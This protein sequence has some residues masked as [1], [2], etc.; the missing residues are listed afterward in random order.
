MSFINKLCRS[1]GFGAG[2]DYETDTNELSDDAPEAEAET[3]V[4][5]TV[6]ET[7]VQG[8]AED[9]REAIFAQVLS[10][11]NEALPDFIARSVNP[12]AQRKLLFDSL[13]QGIK[14]YLATIAADADNRCEQRWSKEQTQLRADMDALRRKSEQIEIERAELKQRQL[15]AER[16]KR[17]LSDRLKDLEKQVESLEAE[18]EQFDL[19]NKSLLNKLKVMSVREPGI[20]ETPVEIDTREGETERMAARIRE[21]EQE[22]DALNLQL[23]QASDRAAMADEIAADLRKRL[24]VSQKEVDDLQA[25]TE[26]VAIVQQAIEERDSTLERQRENIARLKM[27]I[28]TM[29]SSSRAEQEQAR[30]RETELL[31]RIAALETNK[32]AAE[33]EPAAKK[34]RK[35]S[36]GMRKA[37][38]PDI[39]APKI[40]DDDLIDVESGFADHN[41]FGS[42]EPMPAVVPQVS[43]NDDFGYHA[44]EP[45]PRPY[46]D[47]MQMSLFD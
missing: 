12:A 42:D 30:Q 6:G 24:A 46:D 37:A 34:P 38:E 22:R 27:Q 17:A 11:F 7:E 13:D 3:A 9:R 23:Q 36:N 28:D 25:I 2:E 21:L 29:S 19:E 20:S 14:D 45:K 44:P 39:A 43:D 31:E 35:R 40:T 10:V 47:G 1:L 26:Q 16:Q 18:R 8:V 33:D 41:W 32:A 15:S 4:Q 5:K